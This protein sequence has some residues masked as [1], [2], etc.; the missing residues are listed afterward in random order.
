[1]PLFYPRAAGFVIQL[2]TLPV[3]RGH[4]AMK[5][6]LHFA[7]EHAPQSLD[8]AGRLMIGLADAL[9]LLERRS[10]GDGEGVLMDDLIARIQL[11]HD[12]MDG[13]AVSQHAVAIRITV[14]LRSGESGE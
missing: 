9:D 8:Q 12:E 6:Q 14:G 11:R 3:F 7:V 1:M 10:R 13:G 4:P 5:M 2:F